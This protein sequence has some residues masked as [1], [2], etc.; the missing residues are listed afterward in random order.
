[1]SRNKGCDTQP[2]LLLRRACWRIGLRYRLNTQLPGRPDFV[3]PGCKVA[4]FVD[5]CFWHGCPEHYKAPA[6]RATFWQLKRAANARRDERVN[7]A[8]AALGWT[9]V[10]IWE[11]DVRR[12]LVQAVET[13][14]AARGV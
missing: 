8:L 11:H 3:L 6:T 2:E 9:V 14:V 10:R 4:V 13:V 1:M 12:S 7:D 5:G